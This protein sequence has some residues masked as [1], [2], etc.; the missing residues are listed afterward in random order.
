MEQNIE[1]IKLLYEKGF[2]PGPKIC[3]CGANFFKIYKDNNYKINKYSF[4]CAN[5]KCRK[6]FPTTI[7]SFYNNFSYHK[8]DLIS[9]I[10]KCNICHDFN[11]S[12]TQKY[13]QEEKH[14]DVTKNLIR[15]VFHEIRKTINKYLK[16]YYQSQAF[17]EENA[18][19]YFSCDESLINHINGRQIWL[20][21]LTDNTSKELR[22]EFV[23]NRDANTLKYFITAYVNKGNHMVT[24]G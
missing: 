21:G 14:H 5:S 11:V 24:D 4:S 17:G 6:K 3:Q 19:R 20:I 9:E 8:I 2:L 12:K 18:N 15:R 23:D 16:I 7:N 1:K 22:C 13:I 10:I